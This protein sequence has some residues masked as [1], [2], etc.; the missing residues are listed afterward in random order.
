MKYE[1]RKKEEITPEFLEET[2]RMTNGVRDIVFGLIYAYSLVPLMGFIPAIFCLTGIFFY[3]ESRWRF[4]FPLPFLGHLAL[5]AYYI[6]DT[7]MR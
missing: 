2:K 4:L 6:Y 1:P 7:Q 3:W 5:L